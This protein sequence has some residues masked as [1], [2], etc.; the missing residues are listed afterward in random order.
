[1]KIVCIILLC[2]IIFVPIYIVYHEDNIN[3]TTAYVKEIQVTPHG[4]VIL[5]MEKEESKYILLIKHDRLKGA[6]YVGNVKYRKRLS[7][8]EFI[9]NN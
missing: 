7:G 5:S 6:I 9:Q 1:M 4:F 2:F 3:Y 8:Y